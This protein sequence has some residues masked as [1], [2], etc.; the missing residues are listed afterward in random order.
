MRSLMKLRISLL[1]IALLVVWAFDFPAGQNKPGD[2]ASSRLLALENKFNAA[3]K[4]GDIAAM[5]S[6]LAEDFIIT[7]EDG[8]TLSKSGYIADNGRP[9]FHVEIS[10]LSG[11]SVRMH[12]N[13][14]VVTG[15]Y[16]EKG[17]SKGQPYE[18]HDRF[19]DVWMNIN[20]RWQ[21]IASHYSSAT[22]Q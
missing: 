18:Y 11:L 16:H 8:N 14:A 19:T 21:I 12:G 4:S 5:N 17:I 13:T 22:S 15:A 10:D 20:G 3:Y 1:V 6:L 9:D 7:V 2:S